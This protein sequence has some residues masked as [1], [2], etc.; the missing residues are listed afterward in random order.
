MLV[1]PTARLLAVPVASLTDGLDVQLI[2][3][4]VSIGV[5]VLV[6]PTQCEQLVRAITAGQ[7]LWGRN[8]SLLH[9]I[10]HAPTRL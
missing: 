7:F 2:G 1:L 8:E 5:V 10:V 4:I 9:E 6:A 3:A